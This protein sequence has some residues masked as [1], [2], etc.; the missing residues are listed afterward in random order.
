MAVGL[1]SYRV[2]VDLLSIYCW[3]VR[4][5]LVL[6]SGLVGFIGDRDNFLNFII[7]FEILYLKFVFWETFVY[8]SVS[9]NLTLGNALINA[10]YPPFL[11]LVCKRLNYQYNTILYVK[12]LP[13]NYKFNIEGKS[14]QLFY[15]NR[16]GTFFVPVNQFHQVGR[17]L[18]LFIVWLSGVML[19]H[20][21]IH[22]Y[23]YIYNSSRAE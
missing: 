12:F 2:I 16:G 6:W 1:L 4:I 21:Y 15:I 23:I 9:C 7:D 18:S 11:V 8:T 3:F 19:K 5:L 14:E 17:F 22:I 13:I 20:I 10:F